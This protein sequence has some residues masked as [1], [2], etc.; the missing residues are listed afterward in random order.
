MGRSV[1]KN[2][3]FSMANKGVSVLFPLVTVSYISRVL[4]ASGV[5][6]VSAAQNVSAY[7]TMAAALGIPAYGVRAIAQARDHKEL[8]DKTFSEL[9]VVNLLST[10]LA[11]MLYF[12][13]LFLLRENAPP[14]ALSLAFSGAVFLN[15]INIEWV[16]QGFE[17]YEYITIRSL[18]VKTVS[19]LLLFVFVRQKTDLVAYALVICFGNFGNSVLNFI[20][21]KKYVAFRYNGLSLK[22]HL[23]PVMTFFVSVLAIEIYSLLDISMLTAMTDTACVGYYSNATRIVK[24]VGNTLTGISLVLMPRFSYL[25]AAGDTKAV[26]KL[27]GQFLNLTLMLS[28]PFCVGA[29]LL[30][31]QIVQVLF[32]PGFGPA[33]R[34]IRMLSPLIIFMPLSGG[35]FCQLLL[36]AGKEK[37]Y[38]FCVVCGTAVNA[39]LNFALIPLF[40]QNG[41]ALASA[42][43][44]GTVSVAMVLVSRK[45]LKTAVPCRDLASILLSS[46]FM[47]AVV[48]LLR[49]ATA[50]FAVWVAL[51]LEVLAGGVVYFAGIFLLKNSI[52]APVIRAIR[53]KR[54]G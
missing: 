10:L 19:I 34:T 26:Q 36:T 33:V 51:L 16:Y 5:G 38:L 1:P 53:R 23:G 6:E 30:A 45:I 22:R 14:A 8:C 44:E 46:V 2:S 43:A 13:A 32:G 3:V 49:A 52:S 25:F 41:A 4:G 24:A 17:E 15:V 18:A 21:L 11:T 39:A 7:F 40:R 47:A 28:V 37:A 31:G 20:H 50:G 29:S 48:V 54:L 12:A 42:F 27:S 35:V 9:F